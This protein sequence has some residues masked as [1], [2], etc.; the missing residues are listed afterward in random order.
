MCGRSQSH[1]T[2]GDDLLII[3]EEKKIISMPSRH[4]VTDILQRHN[5]K[6]I[7]IFV[8]KRFDNVKVFIEWL[9]F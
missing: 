1:S 9:I 4:N 7:S 3:S 2:H 5:V 6:K 8:E